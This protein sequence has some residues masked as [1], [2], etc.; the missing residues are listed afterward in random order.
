MVVYRSFI[1]E[2]LVKTGGELIAGVASK[3]LFITEDGCEG[4]YLHK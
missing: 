1:D 2:V 3:V 4:Q